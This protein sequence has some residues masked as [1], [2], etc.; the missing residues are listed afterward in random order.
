MPTN[1]LEQPIVVGIDASEP[2][3]YA[4]QWASRAAA[5][6]RAPLHVVFAVPQYIDTPLDD[7]PV[8]LYRSEYRHFVESALASAARDAHILAGADSPIE[9]R[10]FLI[11][12]HPVPALCDLAR[13]ARYVVVGSRGLGAY[14][15]SVLGSVSTALAR[16]APGSVVVVPEQTPDYSPDP[17]VIGVDG[18]PYSTRAV[19]IAFDE[20]ARRGVELVAVHAWNSHG[21]NTSPT[22]AE[23]G[24]QV[25]SRVLA[26]QRESFPGVTVREVLVQD[27]P[28]RALLAQSTRA[29]LVV[30]ASHGGGGFPGMTLGSTSQGVLHAIDRPLIIV[31]PRN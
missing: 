30:V 28:V 15:R 17:V 3:R 21:D 1:N 5:T 6:R 23:D 19:E 26:R 16:H 11:D 9:V 7:S 13:T 18:S 8:R 29:Q 31:R 12:G 2:S 20:A 25:L 10:T 14:L 27:R 22:T 24:E 4:L